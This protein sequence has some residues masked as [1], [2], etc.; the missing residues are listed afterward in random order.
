L[1][2]FTVTTVPVFASTAVTITATYSGSK[3]GVLT[4]TPNVAF[5]MNR[6]EEILASA[7]REPEEVGPDE[8]QATE[9]EEIVTAPTTAPATAPTART[10][11][12]KAPA[13]KLVSLWTLR[14]SPFEDLFR[15]GLRLDSNDGPLADD[16]GGGN[17]LVAG[18]FWD[19][20]F[21]S[22]MMAA[23][24]SSAR[25]P[26]VSTGSRYFFYTPEMNLMAETELTS[27]S[28]PAILYEYIWFNGQPVA[29]MDSAGTASLTFT[30]HLGTPLIQTSSVQGITWR[31]EHEPY[32][33]VFALRTP[34]Q[35]QPLRLPGQEAEQ[36]NL[37]PNGVTERS[38]NIFRWYRNGW[39]RYTQPDPIGIRG[40]TNLFAYALE[41]P[42]TYFDSRGLKVQRCCRPAQ[43][44]FGLV[45][46]CWLKTDTYEAG[47]GNEGGNVPGN[48]S[49]CPFTK[50]QV[51]SH[52][53]QSDQSGANCTDLPNTDEA[54]VNKFIGVDPNGLGR[55]TGRISP[56]N[57][58]Q[59]WADS[60]ARECTPLK[61]PQKTTME[62]P[63][64][65]SWQLQ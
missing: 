29:Q 14:R 64:P 53:G 44:L 27:N 8:A 50:T 62:I 55:P 34:D 3:T 19:L 48:R 32:G 60:V 42:L 30:D 5:L 13:F 20:G 12:E 59:T 11:R 61:C 63:P 45:D 47:M 54:C 43:I 6:Q 25:T 1:N 21:G 22:G 41:N 26:L 2:T 51:V 35:H 16:F 46:H 57:N 37:G 28:T 39:G 18:P 58:C 40:T 17:G 7:S 52:R 33:E 15:A 38:Y 56:W 24:A 49:D 23:R 10:P 9:E 36:L 65:V 4:V 31:A